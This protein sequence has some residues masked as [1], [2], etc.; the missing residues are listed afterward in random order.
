MKLT[1]WENVFHV[2]GIAGI[3]WSACWLY[4]VY[5]S[6][7]IHPRIHPEEKKFILESLGSS[8]VREGEEKRSV[9]WK[10]I[11][12]SRSVWM[13]TIAQWGSVFGLFTV[14]TQAPTYFRFIHGW[15]I[16]MTGILS[17]LPHFLRVVFSMIF[18]CIGDYLL[19]SQKMTRNNVRRLATFVSKF[20]S[21]SVEFIYNFFSPQAWFWMDLRF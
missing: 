18:S 9:P 13:N 5:D 7:E 19:S 17:G 15:G 8:V 16:E 2:C 10:A 14:M 3:V 4:F 11:L 12:T 21:S 6:P 20:S 1:C